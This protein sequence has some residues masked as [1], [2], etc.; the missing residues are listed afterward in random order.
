M[1]K[2][3]IT[4]YTLLLFTFFSSSAQ[5]ESKSRD[6]IR[7]FIDCNAYCPM[8]YVKTEITFVDFVPDR[9]LANVYIQVTSQS[10]GSDGEEVKMF[11]SGQENFKG[12]ED[13][14]KFFRNS[15][16][17]DEE[18]REK[19]VQHLKLALVPYI[20]KTSMAD[21]IIIS[22]PKGDNGKALNAT[23]NKKDKWDFWVFNTRLNGGF[24]KD[25]YSKS[26]RYSAG[27]SGS[28]ITEKLKLD[29][30]INYSKNK[31]VIDI[32]GDKN[33]YPNDN[34][35]LDGNAVV[36]ITNHW[37]YGGG[38]SFSHSTFSN[39]NKKSDLKP[40]IEYSFFPYKE[41]VKKAITIYYE[42][43]PSWN[44]YIDSS[45]YDQVKEAVFQQGLSVNAEFVQ[46]W[47]NINA[48]AGWES[49]LNSFNLKGNKINGA[50][51]NNISIGGYVEFR[52]VKGL[53]VS[54]NFNAGFT[55]GI[56][57]NIRKADFSS[58]DILSNVRQYP[59]SN[60]FYSSF[61][62]RYRFGSIYNNVV[63]PRFNSAGGRF[64]FF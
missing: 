61:G 20:S 63:N 5:T 12:K 54:V 21:K 31:R 23:E 25:D 60:N 53:T 10:T 18:Y 47:G 4:S 64:Y 27:F 42:L 16:D 45:Y 22:V 17:T 7:V 19:F 40:G 11:I 30:S 37:S 41:A 26:Y 59:T 8:Q 36:S 57:P 24:N 55:K 58:D 48:Y 34:Y 56:Y 35:G 15:V 13:T 44:S 2:Q 46:K 14:L 3:F 49:F 50:S 38:A 28:R 43:G 32:A 39:Y 6:E 52:I 51:V 1:R 33:I 29:A 9:F 62:I